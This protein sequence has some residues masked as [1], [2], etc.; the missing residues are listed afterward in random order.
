MVTSAIAPLAPTGVGCAAVQRKRH[1]FGTVCTLQPIA[2][3]PALSG[4]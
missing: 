3:W 4:A 1:R 2:L